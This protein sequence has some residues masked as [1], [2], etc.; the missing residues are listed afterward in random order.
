MCA[1]SADF[2]VQYRTRSLVN[3]PVQS[4]GSAAIERERIPIGPHGPQA[5]VLQLSPRAPATVLA[6]FRD[7]NQEFGLGGHGVACLRW[8]EQAV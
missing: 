8:R 2:G 1:G 7:L 5:M 4:S 6:L 3:F